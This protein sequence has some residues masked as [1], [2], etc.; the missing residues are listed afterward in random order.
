MSSPVELEEL[1]RTGINL[2]GIVAVLEKRVATHHRT[3]FWSGSHHVKCIMMLE[4]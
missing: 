4:T 1:P 2:L 3:V